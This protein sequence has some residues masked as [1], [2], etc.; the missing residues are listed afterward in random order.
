MKG[1]NILTA[2]TCILLLTSCSTNDVKTPDVLESEEDYSWENPGD[3][4]G[5]GVDAT[6][7]PEDIKEDVSPLEEGVNSNIV[8]IE[9]IDTTKHPDNAEQITKSKNINKDSDIY[10]Y[11]NSEITLTSDDCIRTNDNLT[12]S[13]NIYIYLEGATIYSNGSESESDHAFKIQHDTTL[14]LVDGT[15]NKIIMGELNQDNNAI[16]ASQGSSLTI[17][18]NGSL[19]IESNKR[20]IDVDGD[21]VISGNPTININSVNDCIRTGDDLE[22]G[23]IYLNGG[24]YNL[25]SKEGNGLDGS[26][27]SILNEAN[28]DITTADSD[29]IKAE[30]SDVYDDE[31]V[32]PSFSYT[33]GYV[34]IG[35][36]GKIKLTTT[37]EGDAI[38]ADTFIYIKNGIYEISCSGGAPETVTS[39]TSNNGEAKALKAGTIDY[40]DENGKEHELDSTY[41]YIIAIAGGNF[42]ISSDDDAIHS[43]G[44]L[45]IYGG[46][47]EIATGDDAIHAE[48]DLVIEGEAYINIDR[49]YEGV[50]AEAIQINGGYLGLYAKDDGINAASTTGRASD[51][52]CQII[53][54]DGIVYVDAEGDGIDSNGSILINGGTIYVNGPSTGADA[55]LDSE[56]GIIVNGGSVI[57]LAALGMVE[58]PSTSSSQYCISFATSSKQSAG[59]LISV[60]DQ[61]MNLIISLESVRQ[62]QSIILTSPEFKKGET[63]SIYGGTSKL[64]DVTISSIITSAGSTQSGNGNM[65]PGGSSGPG[66]SGGR[67]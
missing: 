10:Y 46:T 32:T 64:Y 59:T 38:Q 33:D 20:G 4:L 27:I 39:K 13:E 6:E 28:L 67:P 23:Q 43:N 44:S 57:A 40:T 8:D 31:Y 15:E 7:I 29:A 14:I 65:G 52:N 19:T 25:E 61:E 34:Y 35:S 9:D 56:Y 47:F 12:T 21:L 36:A 5:G 45:Y 16:N 66:G 54:N 11:I 51:R 41:E 26:Y 1:K 2:L 24:T 17:L 48:T 62:F 55:A 18:G 53:I 63:Y 30:I 3:N 37:G 49:C 42:N 60:Y 50:E 22:G 58:T